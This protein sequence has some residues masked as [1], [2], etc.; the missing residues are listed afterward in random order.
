MVVTKKRV[1]RPVMVS[2]PM[3]QEGAD[4]TSQVG[5]WRVEA[6]YNSWGTM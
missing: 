4:A 3:R 2:L 5:A 1:K 6:L